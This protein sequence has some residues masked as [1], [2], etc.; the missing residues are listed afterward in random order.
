[1]LD[2]ETVKSICS[3]MVRSGSE[4]S[5]RHRSKSPLMYAYYHTEYLGAAHGLSSI[6]QMIISCPSYLNS[7]PHANQLVRSTVDWLLSTQQPD[8]NFAPATDELGSSHPPSDQL[9]HWCHGAPGVVYLFAKAFLFWH[10]ERYLQACIQCGEI[11]WLRGLLTKGP[12]ICHGVA[13]SGYV[14]LLLYRLTN[15]KK[16]LHR[17]VQ[18]AQFLFTQE[19]QAGAR[20]PDNPYS[21]YEGLAGTVCFMLDL[22]QPEKAEF[23]FLD[24]F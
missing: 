19:F 5:R 20:T 18:F 9:V 6:L 3:A 7:D 24:V 15:D 12:G 2:E 1:I 22:L 4:Y 11:T 14:F 8:G 17:A 10:E 13:G 23:P 21:L 16:Y